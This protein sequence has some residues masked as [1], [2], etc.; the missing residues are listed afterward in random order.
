MREKLRTLYRGSSA[1][2]RVFRFAI[3]AFDIVTI[4]FFIVSSLMR[5]QTWI[6]VVDAIIAVVIIADLVARYWI[7]SAAS[8]FCSRQQH[9]PTSSS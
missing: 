7:S 5:D 6:Y 2:A 1:E 4:L 8:A 3:L 9:G